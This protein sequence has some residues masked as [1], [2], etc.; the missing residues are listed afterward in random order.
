[1]LPIEMRIKAEKRMRRIFYE[2]RW[3]QPDVVL[4]GDSCIRIYWSGR[5]HSIIVDITEDGEIGKS[6]LGDPPP[7]EEQYAQGGP[8]ASPPDAAA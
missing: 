6:R 3:A 4:Y 2:E 5:P 8:H 7:G 1:M